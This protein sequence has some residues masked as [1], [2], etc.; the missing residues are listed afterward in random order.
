M[1]IESVL[2]RFAWNVEDQV[3]RSTRGVEGATLFQKYIYIFY[4]M[5]DKFPFINY[6]TLLCLGLYFLRESDCN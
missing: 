4:L 1:K 5:I 2:L 3:A 6:L